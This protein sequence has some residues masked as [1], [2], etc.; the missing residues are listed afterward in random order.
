VESVLASAPLFAALDADAAAALSE[1]ITSRKLD[2][3]HV[4]FREGDTGDRLFVV[5]DGKVKISRAAADGRENLLAVLGTSEMFG[6]LSLFDPGPRT[7]TVTTVTE[8]T[9]ASLDHDDLRPLL[10]ERPGVAVQLL[11]ALAQRLR[12]TNEAM[13]DLVFTDVPG[14]VAKALLDLAEKFGAT[15]ADGTRVRHDLTQE[16][17]AQLVGAS[18]ETVNKALSEFAHRGWLRIEGR[19]VLLLEPER[20]ARRAR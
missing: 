11:Q 17:L 2:R 18:R 3:G 10:T 6:E 16:E 14:R 5:L 15:E 20:L 1:M 7:A 12:R 8:A 4:V 13:A 19:S 9:L